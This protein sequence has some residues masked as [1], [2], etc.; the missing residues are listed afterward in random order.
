MVV[1]AVKSSW[2]SVMSGVRQALLLGSVLL[3]IFIDD[4]DEGI[5]CTLS[6]FADD[7]KLGGSLNL[8]EG[9]KVLQRGLDRLDHWAEANGMKF[10]KTKWQVLH[11]S[12]NNPMQ[13]YRLGAEWLE[14]CAEEKDLW[15][16]S[17]WLNMSQQCAQVAKKT[18]GILV[19]IRNSAARRSR[20]VVIPMYSAGDGDAAS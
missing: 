12:R 8:L 14:G 13:C 3:N 5:E 1:N 4:L 6:K 9:R 18:N 7:I 19:Y 16:F 15:L 17:A 2:Q 11:F 20:E 10:N